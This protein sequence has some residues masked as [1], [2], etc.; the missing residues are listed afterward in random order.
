M[1]IKKSIATG[2]KDTA[3]TDRGDKASANIQKEKVQLL[4]VTVIKKRQIQL[5]Q[6]MEMQTQVIQQIQ[7]QGKQIE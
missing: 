6:I 4:Q 7:V 5:I 1:V 2:E 3:N